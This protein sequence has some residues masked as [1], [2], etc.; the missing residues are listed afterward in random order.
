M[1]G[2]IIKC[3]VS[4]LVRGYD[5]V[6]CR[7]LR[8]GGLASNGRC[9]IVY[10]HSVRLDEVARFTEQLDAISREASI[11]SLDEESRPSSG[12]DVV[13]VTIDDGFAET[14]DNILPVLKSR[15][16]PVTIFVPTGCLGERAPWL[17]PKGASDDREHVMSA[18]R[19]QDL[20][21][22]RGIALQSHCIS[23]RS[24]LKLDDAEA[25]REVSESKGVLERLLNRRVDL[26]SFPHGAFDSRH[27]AMCREAGYRR[28]FG[29]EPRSAFLEPGE[30][31]TGRIRVDPSD[32]RLEFRLKM[33][34]AYRWL[35]PASKAK[36][37][38]M[39]FLVPAGRSRRRSP[40]RC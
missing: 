19:I 6:R 38:A 33:H 40:T 9:T 13:Y 27:I 5:L 30:F 37:R 17:T 29:I 23:H 20:A 18:A 10:Y 4:L 39:A 34:G 36:R 24:L 1:T 12:V 25:R 7:V 3:A 16:A 21:Q 26:L 11:G 14:I 31:V 2:R 22:L 15:G 32:S 8:L 35:D 28:V